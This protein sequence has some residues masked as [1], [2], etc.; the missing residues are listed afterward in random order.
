MIASL[1]DAD[2]SIRRRALDLL[3]AMCSH[4]NAPDIVAELL[5]Y[6]E[7]RPLACAGVCTLHL[8]QPCSS[9]PAYLALR[10]RS[11]HQ[12][13]RPLALR[14]ARSLHPHKPG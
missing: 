5:R 8:Q 1:R 3:F 12:L 2:V 6:L 7:A 9:R 11:C 14:S 10:P 4:A 13:A